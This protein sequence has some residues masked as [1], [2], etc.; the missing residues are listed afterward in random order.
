MTE[1]YDKIDWPDENSARGFLQAVKEPALEY[2]VEPT[3]N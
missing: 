3:A 2:R 1:V